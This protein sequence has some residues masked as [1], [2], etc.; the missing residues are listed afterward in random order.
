MNLPTIK[1]ESVVR[2]KTNL[3]FTQFDDEFLSIDEK[4]GYC[5]SLNSSGQRIWELL[6]NPISVTVLC[7]QLSAEFNVEKETCLNDVTLLLQNLFESDL[8]ELESAALD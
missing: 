4:A 5:Y 8:I 7:N 3:E 1:L 2:R 6:A